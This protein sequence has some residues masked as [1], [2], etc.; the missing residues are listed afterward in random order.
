MS[1]AGYP[2][3]L[4]IGLVDEVIALVIWPSSLLDPRKYR[5][6]RK[7]KPQTQMLMTEIAFSCDMSHKRI[8]ESNGTGLKGKTRTL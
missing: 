1:P 2:C 3:S 8:N 5:T 4:N 6:A 7:Q